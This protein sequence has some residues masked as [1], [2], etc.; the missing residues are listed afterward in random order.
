MKETKVAIELLD[1]YGDLPVINYQTSG[2]A[3]FDFYAALDEPL[4]IYPGQKA[5]IP[6]GIR[7]ALPEG[8]ELQVRPRSGL[9]AKHAVTVLNSPGTVDSDYRGEVK[10]ILI[11]LGQEPF[12]VERGMRIAQGVIA[13]YVKASF[14]VAESLDD[15]DRGSGGFGHTGV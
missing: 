15:T 12:T 1:H 13:P 6:T 7:F 14:Q 3:G 8:L 11:N 2:A 10:V 5:M 4:V 9:A